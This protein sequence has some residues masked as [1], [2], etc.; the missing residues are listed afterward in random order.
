MEIIPEI[1]RSCCYEIYMNRRSYLMTKKNV[2]NHEVFGFSNSQIHHQTP[3]F[4]PGPILL[5]GV[6]IMLN[7][8]YDIIILLSLYNSIFFGI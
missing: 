7:K 6:F 5:N 2:P 8:D 4:E 1:E 3:Q